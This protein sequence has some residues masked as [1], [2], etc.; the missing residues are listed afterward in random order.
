MGDKPITHIWVDEPAEEPMTDLHRRKIKNA[1]IYFFGGKP[2]TKFAPVAPIHIYEAMA[3]RGYVPDNI[4]LLAHDVVKEENRKRYEDLFINRWATTKIIMDNSLIELGG[5]VDLPMLKDAVDIVAADVVVLPD[6]LTDGMES[7]RLTLENWDPFRTAFDNIKTLVVIQGETQKGFFGAL[8]WLAKEIDPDWISIP[9]RTESKFGYHRR[10]LIDFVELF[11]PDKP[12]HLLGFSEYPWEDVMAARH[13]S[14]LSIDSAAPLR[15][16]Y[17]FS[18]PGA[19][20]VKNG[21]DWWD[22]CKFDKSMLQ[23]IQKINDL[24][25]A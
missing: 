12:I 9:R 16:P 24:I 13:E 4:L 1:F 5:S 3:N 2:V 8:E 23:N 21:V 22:T 25:G 15:S 19:P 14:V 6:S 18:D 7:A 17:P 11:F 20:R 10:E